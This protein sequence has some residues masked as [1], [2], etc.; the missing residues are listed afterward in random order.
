GEFCACSGMLPSDA[1]PIP[2]TTMNSLT[3]ITFLS[4][5]TYMTICS[6]PCN[7]A[8]VASD[9]LHRVGWRSCRNDHLYLL[10]VRRG[11]LH[12]PVQHCV[13]QSA[14]GR[15]LNVERVAQRELDAALH[16]GQGELLRILRRHQQRD[17]REILCA[18]VGSLLQLG[19][20]S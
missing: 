6:K 19:P 16:A 14:W 5:R 8:L 12:G 10:L 13:F 4:L 18:A 2:T 3:F 20:G 17:H 1:S 15:F 7:V 9:Q 11:G